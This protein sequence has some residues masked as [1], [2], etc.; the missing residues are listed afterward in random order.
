MSMRHFLRSYYIARPLCSG[1]KWVLCNNLWRKMQSIKGAVLF[2][3]CILLDCF[4]CKSWELFSKLSTAESKQ[5]CV[6][7]YQNI[8]QQL[9]PFY[10][11][12]NLMHEIHC[13][14]LYLIW[15]L[16]LSHISSSFF[17]LLTL[18][19]FSVDL[20]CSTERSKS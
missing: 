11:T 4:P 12:D 17:S 1:L 10:S 18:W 13:K 7:K 6:Q 5:F 8:I 2:S 9:L 3:L 16:H 14:P 19:A 20:H 15:I